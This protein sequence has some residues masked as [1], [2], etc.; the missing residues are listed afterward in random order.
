[1][2]KK[3]WIALCIMFIVFGIATMITGSIALAQ[4]DPYPFIRVYGY[5][6]TLWAI[7]AITVFAQ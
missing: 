4:D 1:M 7:V 3:Q 6:A 2:N 5:L